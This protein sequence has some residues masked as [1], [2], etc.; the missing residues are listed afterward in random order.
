[1]AKSNKFAFTKRRLEAIDPPSSGRIY[2]HDAGQDNLSL[3]ITANGS[4][5]FYRT[6]RVEGRPVRIRIGKFP[7]LSVEQARKLCQKMAGEIAAGKNPHIER[8]QK[9]LEQTLKSL[10]DW[11]MEHHAKKFKKSWKEDQR[12]YDVYLKAWGS[13]KLRTRSEISY[14]IA[15]VTKRGVWQ[16]YMDAGC[17]SC[18]WNSPK[19]LRAC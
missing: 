11:Y 14:R 6:G 2:V 1:M 4:T 5:T 15:I 13:R 19:V 7:D 8:K 10:F 3:C 9:R 17:N 12:Q 18:K 16:A